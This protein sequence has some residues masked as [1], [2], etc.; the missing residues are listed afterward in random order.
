MTRELIQQIFD[1]IASDLPEVKAFGVFNNT[2][3]R[4]SQGDENGVRL[5]AIYLSFPEGIEYQ[6]NGS[7]AQRSETFTI[8]FNIGFRILDDKNVLDI[9]DFKEKVFEAFH[10]FQ[11]SGSGSFERIAEAA[12]ELHGNIYVFQVDFK[13]NIISTSRFVDNDRIPV[14]VAG[15]VS[16]K[17]VD[18]I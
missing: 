1:K 15:E 11:P 10:K 9:F 2:F 18:N 7:G 13:T 17:Y 14:T 12:D 16:A 8:R 5:P 6:Q 4:I 3:E